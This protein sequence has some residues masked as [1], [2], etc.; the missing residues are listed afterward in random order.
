MIYRY[1]IHD[2]GHMTHDLMLLLSFRP[3][4]MGQIEFNLFVEGTCAFV[5]IDYPKIEN[6]VT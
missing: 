3:I 5:Q 6:V 1:M 4:L 2:T